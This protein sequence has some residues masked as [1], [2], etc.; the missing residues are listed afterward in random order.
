MRNAAIGKRCPTLQIGD[1]LKMFDPHDA[2]VVSGDASEQLV[3]FDV[4]LRMSTEQVVVAKPGCRQDRRAIELGVVKS[5]RRSIP[6]GPDVARHTPRR[7]VNFAYAQ[8]MKAA[9]SSC[10]TL[11]KRT[12]SCFRSSASTTPLIPSPGSPKTVSTP[13][14]P[15]LSMRM[16]AAVL[17][18][19]FWAGYQIESKTQ[20]P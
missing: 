7:P 11:T 18:F 9:A 6:P 13:Q 16:S 14:A 1:G 17:S 3:E 2:R 8:A 4:L 19:A 12:V 5:F 10:L 15:N 20:A